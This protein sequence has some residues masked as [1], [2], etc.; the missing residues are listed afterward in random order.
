MYSSSPVLPPRSSSEFLP[1]LTLLLTA[2]SEAGLLHLSDPLF[3]LP[4]IL[5]A[6]ALQE[7]VLL[8]LLALL[9]DLL[10]R[11]QLRAHSAAAG[12]RLWP[13]PHGALEVR[14]TATTSTS[15]TAAT[16]ATTTASTTATTTTW[17][18]ETWIKNKKLLKRAFTW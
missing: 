12:R 14:V 6:S 7:V 16:T 18:T 4:F 1:H 10:V 15:T 8:V 9:Q 5:Q 11:L 17:E 2:P 13:S 3:A